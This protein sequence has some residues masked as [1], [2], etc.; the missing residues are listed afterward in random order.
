MVVE[1]GETVTATKLLDSRDRLVSFS[2]TASF[3]PYVIIGS[4]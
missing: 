2:S 1:L 4:D 3:S